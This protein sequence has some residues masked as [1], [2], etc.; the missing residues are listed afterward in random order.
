MTN[1]WL[2]L[3]ERAPFWL[4]QDRP[5]VE[6]FNENVSEKYR[7]EGQLLPQPFM[8]P[9]TAPLVTLSLN[10]GLVDEDYELHKSSYRHLVR[11]SLGDDPKGHRH[12]GL[13]PDS[14]DER[15]WWSRRFNEVRR[16]GQHDLDELSRKVLSVEFHGYHARSWRAIPVTLPSQHFS[17]GLVEEAIDRGATIVMTRGRSVWGVAVPRLRGY[18]HLVPLG[19]PRS[20][21][22]SR[23]NLGE[24]GFK[25]VLRALS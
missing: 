17:F 15:R 16:E 7:L 11:A 4:P 3:Q 12:L 1:P 6:A 22:L 8:G 2:E 20:A 18:E 10:P 14:P 5:H 25:K 21:Y 24:D 13:R 19:N 9:R 23:R